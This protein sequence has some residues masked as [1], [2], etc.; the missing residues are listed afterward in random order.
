MMSGFEVAG[1]RTVT[2]ADGNPYITIELKQQ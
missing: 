2:G 1:E